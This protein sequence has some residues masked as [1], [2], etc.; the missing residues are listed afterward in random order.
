MSSEGTGKPI[1]T[2]H[3]NN[4]STSSAT[5]IDWSTEGGVQKIYISGTSGGV[6]PQGVYV[7][8]DTTANSDSFFVP[9]SVGTSLVPVAEFDFKGLG[10]KKIYVLPT[11]GTNDIYILG[12]KN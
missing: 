6:S 10:V 9:L 1:L 4:A 2:D 12:V 8:F 3:K 11:N 7:G 5:L